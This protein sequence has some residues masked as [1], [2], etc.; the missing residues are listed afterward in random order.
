MKIKS[1]ISFTF[2]FIFL[3][4]NSIPAQ[5]TVYRMPPSETYR[6]A[7]TLFEQQN[8]GAARQ[9]FAQ[10]MQEEKDK[11]GAFFENAAY[12]SIVCA[13]E[14]EDKDAYNQALIFAATYPGSAWIPSIHFQLGQLLFKDKKYDDALEMFQQISPQQLTTDQRTEYYYQIGYSQMKLNRYDAAIANFTKI[15]GS[16]TE[17]G[18][19]ANYYYAHLQ[20]MKGN[21]DEALKGFKAIE[22]DRRFKKYVPNYL[23]HIYYI[24]GQF[25]KVVD[26][27]KLYFESADK[28]T[29]KELARLLGNAYYNLKDYKHA[30]EYYT[31][32]E[33]GGRHDQSPGEQYRIGYTKFVNGKEAAAIPN[34]QEATKEGGTM[35]QNA[36]YHLGFCYLATDQQKFAQNAFLKAYK[37]KNDPLLTSDALFNYVKT[38]ITLGGDPYNDPVSTI[39][40]FIK[41]NPGTSESN[42]AYTLLS[43]LYLSSRNYDAAILSIE[44]T[45]RPDKQLQKVYQQITYNQG[46][47][48]FNR[49]AYTDA[50]SYF[51]K[52]QTYPIDGRLMALSMFW[53][54][55]TYYRLKQFDLAMRKFSA[56]LKMR[57]AGQT[58]LIS[59]AQYNMAY[60]SFNQKDYS[61]AIRDFEKFLSGSSAQKNLIADARLRLADSYFILKRYS[62]A[63]QWYQKVIDANSRD[64]DYALY[65]L[66]A[67]YGSAGNFQQKTNSLT[68][69]TE[70]YKASNYYDDAL[71][72]TASTYLIMNDQRLAINYFNRLVKEKP[73]SNLAKKALVK[74]GFLYY[75]NNQFEEAIKVLKQVVDR[76]PASLEAKEALNTLQSIYMDMGKVDQYLTYAKGLDFVQISTSQEDSLTFTSGENYYLNNECDKAIPLLN[77][78]VEQYPNGGFVLTAYHELTQCLEKTGKNQEALVL[79]EKIA[80]LPENQ[81]TTEALIKS[82]RAAFAGGD[83][84]KSQLFY[85]RLSEMD[86][87]PSMRLE[88]LDGMM[89]SAYLNGDNPG[90]KKAATELLMTEKVG[91]DQIINAHFLLGKIA[92]SENN[93]AQAL[94]EFTITTNLSA[95]EKGAESKYHVALLNYR[96]NKLEE[97]ENTV[98]ELSEKYPSSDYWIAKAFILLA[99]IYVGRD[100]IFQAEQTLQSVIENYKGEDLKKIAVEKLKRLQKMNEDRNAKTD[101]ENIEDNEN[102][103]K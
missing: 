86:N 74:M 9:M 44:K 99:D 26:E 34:F 23:M 58:D 38:T 64:A 43:Q 61:V 27:G 5:E 7:L 1:L 18:R 77:K 97:A 91:N 32:Y 2:F 93:Q 29:R 88:S 102:E 49:G 66:A 62:T 42:Q 57:E 41:E 87:N 68:Q 103:T 33:N 79:Y 69:L 80:S 24:Q 101:N 40:E 4:I 98:Y 63:M 95:G 37:L 45:N 16:K 50:L 11:Q 21:Y 56:F 47:E 28:T 3:I 81:Y 17:Y 84:G 67:C 31:E 83:Y 52:S 70:R 25:E 73:T 14:L 48:Y 8:Y 13:V 30:L 46:I 51:E 19:A 94:K 100:N 82:A 65:Q 85:K 90:A 71:Y 20:Y 96:A 54:G 15:T 89:Q 92:M 59:T 53:Q 78:Y 10:A 35:E 39:E 76:Y 36:W 60:A 72:E 12:Y 55:D 22:N 6:N 75:K